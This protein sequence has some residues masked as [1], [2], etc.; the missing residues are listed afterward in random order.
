M[1]TTFTLDRGKH[2]ALEL[3]VYLINKRHRSRSTQESGSWCWKMFDDKK[4]LLYKENRSLDQPAT[5]PDTTERLTGDAPLLYCPCYWKNDNSIR[6][7]AVLF[8]LNA[9]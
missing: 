1:V 8:T 9:T 4:S 6:Y 7:Y 5:L 2:I 3:M